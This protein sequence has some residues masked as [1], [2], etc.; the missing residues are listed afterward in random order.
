MTVLIS[1]LAETNHMKGCL[2]PDGLSGEKYFLN[3]QQICWRTH[4]RNI[5]VL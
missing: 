3:W 1:N 2:E 4:W 5:S